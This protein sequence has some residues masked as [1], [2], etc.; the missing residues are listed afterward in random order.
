MDYILW[1]ISMKLMRALLFIPLVLLVGCQGEKLKP[2][3]DREKK[4]GLM[5]YLWGFKNEKGEIRI[6][7]QYSF[8]R[9]FSEGLAAVQLNDKWGFIDKKGRV[10]IAPKYSEAEPFSEGLALVTEGGESSRWGIIGGT[11]NF[12]DNT[13]KNLMIAGEYDA[14]SSFSEGLAA[15]ELNGKR[16]FIDK[17]GKE[18]IAPKYSEVYPFSEGLAAVRLKN[19]WGFIDKDGEM[20]IAL[21]YH[22]VTSVFSEGLAAVGVENKRKTIWG[23]GNPLKIEI[24]DYGYINRKGDW[25]INPKYDYAFGFNENHLAMIGVKEKQGFVDKDGH[26]YWTTDES[27][28][29]RRKKNR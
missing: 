13:G 6:E 19:K 14:M 5:G 23:S 20:V 21:Q 25:V 3:E 29:L 8:A 18:V 24:A 15:V 16:G 17:K 27:E 28:A 2:F 11:Q 9:P 22:A 4:G 12:I 10:V 1:G 26:E 7:A